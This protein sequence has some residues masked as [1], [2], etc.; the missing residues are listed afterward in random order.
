MFPLGPVNTGP[1]FPFSAAAM[2]QYQIYVFTKPECP[3]CTRLKDSLNRIPEELSRELKMV[4]RSSNPALFD[5]FDVTLHPTMVVSHI[6]LQCEQEDGEEYCTQSESIVEK[7]EGAGNILDALDA[8][9][10]AYT[11]TD[12]E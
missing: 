9:I 6:D 10:S 12:H 5:F 7:I 3:P 11:Y 2:K 4:E 8:T 1:L